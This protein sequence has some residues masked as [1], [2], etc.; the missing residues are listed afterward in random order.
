MTYIIRM[1]MKYSLYGLSQLYVSFIY[2]TPLDTNFKLSH[3]QL[4]GNFAGLDQKLLNIASGTFITIRLLFNYLYI[5][6]KT[7]S[8]AWTRTAAFFSG[9][10]K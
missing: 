1:E 5:N 6:Q 8:V 9:L 10:G 7:D 2:A 4:A 3:F